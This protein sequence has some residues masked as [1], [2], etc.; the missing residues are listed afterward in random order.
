MCSRSIVWPG[1]VIVA[2]CITLSPAL[3]KGATSPQNL[4]GGLKRRRGGRGNFRRRT[5]LWW[6]K[7][8]CQISL[9]HLHQKLLRF[10]RWSLHSFLGHMAIYNNRQLF[11]LVSLDSFYCWHLGWE[12]AWIIGPYIIIFFFLFVHLL[13]GF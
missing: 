4:C 9:L 1:L 2:W 8:Q 5:G 11:Y 7:Y 13:V 12:I 10:F 3:T 6:E